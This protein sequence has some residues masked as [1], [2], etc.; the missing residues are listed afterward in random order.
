MNANPTLLQMKY[1]RIINIFSERAG[2]SLDDA[3]AFFYYSDLYHLISRGVSDMHCMSDAY[4][5]EDLMEEYRKNLIIFSENDDNLE[6]RYMEKSD[7]RLAISKVYE[8][9]WKYAYKGIVPQ[10]YLE[11]I[12][13]GK[14]ASN[15]EQDNRK[16][17]IVV[18]DKTIIGTAGF[19][20][21]RMDEMK[22]FGEIIS[23]Y[24]LPEYMGKG[25]GRLLLQTVL[26]ELKKMDFDSVFLWVLEENK[27]ARKFYEKCGFVQSERY[28]INNIGGKDLKEVQYVYHDSN[29]L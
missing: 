9:S 2:L 13:E 28:L 18:K 4:L 23:I 1:A 6:I 15:I 26:G 21:S 27:H 22:G 5:V 12:P 3:L 29:I 16:N 8:E 14:W 25:Y 17:L 24:L 11:S 19:G 7:S 20:K 10:I